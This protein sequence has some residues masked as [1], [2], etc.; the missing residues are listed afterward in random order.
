MPNL[1]SSAYGI[2]CLSWL[3]DLLVFLRL[4]IVQRVLQSIHN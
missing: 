2:I 4:T 1:L 3:I